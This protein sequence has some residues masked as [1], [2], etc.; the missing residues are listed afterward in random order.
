MDSGAS[1]SLQESMIARQRFYELLA[2]APIPQSDT[3]RIHVGLAAL[4]T[5]SYRFDLG[6]QCVQGVAPG[7]GGRSSIERAVVKSQPHRD[8][9]PDHFH[10]NYL[11]QRAPMDLAQQLDLASAKVK[12]E[13]SEP[14]LFLGY[15]KL[16]LTTKQLLELMEY[17]GVMYPKMMAGLRS[18]APVGFETSEWLEALAESA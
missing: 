17:M 2:S 9:L 12:A 14:L 18:F 11:R 3:T 4:L 6:R 15:S 13:I 8:W 1:M 10:Y 16:P 5:T 7:R